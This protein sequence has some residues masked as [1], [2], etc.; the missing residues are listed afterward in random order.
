[1]EIIMNKRIEQL[2]LLA[3]EYVNSVYTPPVRS[4]TPGKIWEDGHVGWHT[5]F[6]EKFAELIVRECVRYFN[7]DYQRD[8][9]TM[10][11]ED[12]SKGIKKHFGVE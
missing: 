6:N 10:W 5:Q 1:M 2:A 11:R 9:D 7:E 4:K 8:F 3:G 12:L